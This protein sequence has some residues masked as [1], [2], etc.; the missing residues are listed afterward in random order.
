MSR[1]TP[2]LLDSHPHPH[3]LVPIPVTPTGFRSKRVQ[4]HDFWTR[5]KVHGYG[6]HD[7]HPYPR[8]PVPV[9]RMGSKT[10]DIPYSHPLKL[11]NSCSLSDQSCPA[12]SRVIGLI[13]PW[14]ISSLSG[15]WLRENKL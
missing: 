12:F 1:V 15:V 5:L 4:K 14:K 7:P 10:H 2:G 8:L 3:P 11:H 6:F 13:L 9:T